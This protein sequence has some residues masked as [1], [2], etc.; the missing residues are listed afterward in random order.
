MVN[1]QS[2]K[3]LHF[4]VTFTYS[5]PKYYE[6]GSSYTFSKLLDLSR[7]N[8]QKNAL[9]NTDILIKISFTILIYNILYL[10]LIPKIGIFFSLL[11]LSHPLH[12]S[13]SSIALPPPFL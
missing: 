10:S 8:G 12:V 2:P 5:I 9:I 7:S 11:Y 6:M 4:Q 3:L 13:L 1:T